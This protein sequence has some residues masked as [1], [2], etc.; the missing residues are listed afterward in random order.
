L[1]PI[2]TIAGSLPEEVLGEHRLM[3]EAR[4]A[5][6]LR[7]DDTV[8]DRLERDIPQL[9]DYYRLLRARIG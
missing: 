2:F 4:Y 9:R 3:L 8:F 1:S 5:G 7:S 6:A